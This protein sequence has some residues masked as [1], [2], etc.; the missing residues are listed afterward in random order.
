MAD[1]LAKNRNNVRDTWRRIQ[2]SS[3]RTVNKDL[4]MR[5]H[6]ERKSKHGLLRDNI[7]W[8]A[9]S[10]KL[11]TR[12]DAV[13]TSRLCMPGWL[14]QLNMYTK[15]SSSMVKDGIWDDVD[16]YRLLDELFKLDAC[17]VDDVDWDNLLDH[18]SGD[19]CRKRW[20]QMVNHI[21]EHGI[22]S[23]MQ[24]VEVLAKRY[25]PELLETREAFDS[26]PCDS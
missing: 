18:R 7:G 4:R 26:M 1:V 12:T 6:E 15:L 20:R 9:I 22:K 19:V 8:Q 23:F 5:V 10:H 21:G 17:C 25:C 13:L 11:A 2:L 3:L 24:Q 16:D 14:M